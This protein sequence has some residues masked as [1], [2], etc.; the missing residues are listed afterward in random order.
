MVVTEDDTAL[1]LGTG[2][3]PVL[4]TP[5]VVALLEEAAVNA[6]HPLLEPGVSTVAVRVQM[7]HVSPTAIGGSVKAEA[8]LEKVE[9]RRLIF[10]A[11]ARDDRGLVAAGKVTRVVVNV[12][13]FLEK[14]R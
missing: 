9:G 7:E 14:T 10:Q 4:S 6:V 2:E 3:V 5:R 13:Q 12:E 11:S 1:A 8:T